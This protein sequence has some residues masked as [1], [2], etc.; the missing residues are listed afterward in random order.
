MTRPKVYL[1][2]GNEKRGRVKVPELNLGQKDVTWAKENILTDRASTSRNRI[3]SFF[4]W[5]KPGNNNSN[6][7]NNNNNNNV[8]NKNIRNLEE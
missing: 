3:S 5:I 8:K 6:N 2:D 7:N 4:S 1:D